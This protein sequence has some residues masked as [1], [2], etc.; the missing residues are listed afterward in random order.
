MTARTIAIGDIHGCL[1]ALDTLLEAI[2][3]CEEDTIVTL[4]DVVDRGPESRGVVE[5]VI[6][7]GA[8]CRLV[9]LLGN[10][11]A[12]MLDALQDGDLDFWLTCGG[13]ETV[14]SYGGKMSDVPARHIE[15]LQQC[16]LYWESDSH[17]FVHANYR[18]ELPLAGQ[19]EQSLLWEH[20]TFSI[21]GPHVSGKTAV[22]G[23]TPQ[24]SCEILDLGY[25]KCIDTF[26][27]GGGW[28]TALDVHT[29][30]Q[31]QADADGKL[32]A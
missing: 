10:H 4:G 18:A 1:A 30:Q 17:L 16:P 31:W 22:V 2:A 19:P 7:L 6:E 15:F 26:C 21:P 23:H 29:G 27:I 24:R 12:M 28:L 9:P 3:P 14:D 5:R 11:E 25:L 20:L 32:N 13:A 8:R